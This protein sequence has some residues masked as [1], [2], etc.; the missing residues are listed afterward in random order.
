MLLCVPPVIRPNM[1]ATLG[2]PVKV[3]I[4]PGVRSNSLKLWKR[5]R[6]AATGWAWPSSGV[7]R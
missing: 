7:I 6:G 4:S 3:A 1:L 2:G 5:L